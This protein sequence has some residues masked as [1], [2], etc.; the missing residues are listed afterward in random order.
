MEEGSVLARH[1]EHRRNFFYL[2]KYLPE[3]HYF[4]SGGSMAAVSLLRNQK[5]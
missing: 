3:D 4:L 1:M 2:L 5:R